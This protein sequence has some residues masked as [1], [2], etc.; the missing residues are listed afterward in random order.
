MI[1]RFGA[2]VALI[3]IA[4]SGCASTIPGLQDA[5]TRLAL[6]G[7][8][9]APVGS[10][11]RI[12]FGRAQPG[13]VEAVSRL[14]GQTPVREG[15]NRE[16]GAGPVYAAQWDTGLT[17]NFMDGQFLGWVVQPPFQGSYP[18]GAQPLGT[19]V[20]ALGAAGLEHTSLGR[21]F[22]VGQVYHL[23]GDGQSSVS[24][25][26]SGLTCFFR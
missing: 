9:I 18:A 7:G 6:D 13:V 15:T 17:L 2:G 22:A 11:L 10:D 20:S 14:L 1:R 4:L 21:E 5:P 8:G 12:D 19:P 26:W 3:A 24:T 16:C 23:V 25:V